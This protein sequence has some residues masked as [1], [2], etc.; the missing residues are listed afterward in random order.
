MD[1][2]WNQ[3]K[4]RVSELHHLNIQIVKTRKQKVHSMFEDNSKTGEQVS[5]NR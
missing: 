2:K 1:W 3:R 4:Q 5:D